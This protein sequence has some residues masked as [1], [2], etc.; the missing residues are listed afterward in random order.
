MK[1]LV[2][3]TSSP[4]GSICFAEGSGSSAS[5]LFKNSWT[6]KKVK[7][8]E[9]STNPSH[10]ELVGLAVDEGLKKLSLSLNDL[11]FF[12]TTIG[13][14]SFTG[15][16]VGI[17]IV[18]SYCYTLKKPYLKLD[19]LKALALN[20]RSTDLP[21]V[22]LVNAFKNQ[23]YTAVYDPQTLKPL[24]N[25]CSLTLEQLAEHIK[26]PHLCLGDGYDIYQNFFTSDLKEN[27]VRSLEYN[28]FPQAET[29]A[30]LA[31]HNMDTGLDLD[32]KLLNPLY[33]RHSEAEEK[34]SQGLL[35][36]MPK[37]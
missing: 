37:L 35:K 26:S 1:Y 28:D 16:R 6:R 33:I 23:V 10:S 2:I 30:C 3:E 4:Q 15:I 13:P 25:P 7:A 22:C 20:A 36:P 34:L 9:R 29:I 12:S 14:G 24:L 32:W 18:K 19:S 17:N 27:L 21:I 8:K 5:I 31:A 11:D